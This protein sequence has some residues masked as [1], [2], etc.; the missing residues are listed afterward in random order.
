MSD[1]LQIFSLVGRTAL[2][3]GASRGLGRAMAAALAGAG[4]HVILA[5]RDEAKLATA[6]TEIIETGGSASIL[7]LEL[8]DERA[9]I[10][11]VRAVEADH[12]KLDILL[13]NA[14]IIEWTPLAEGKTADWRRI[15]D[16]NVTSMFILSREAAKGMTERRWGRIINIGSV[17]SILGR[18]NLASYCASKAAIAGLTKSVAAELGPHNVTCNCILP[19]YFNTE[20]NQALTARPGYVEMVAGCAPLDRWGD[21]KE[22]GGVAIFLASDASSFVTGQV[23]SVDGGISAAFVIPPAA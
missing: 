6:Q 2:V 22:L 4:A 18:A 19:G 21:P 14:G 20:I 3:T 10:E 17:L 1:V 15:V 13:N 12:G 16:T 23:I 11:A 8:T 7:P 9:C 5:A